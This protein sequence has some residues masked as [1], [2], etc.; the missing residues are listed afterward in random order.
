MNRSV[1]WLM[2]I[3]VTLMLFCAPAA[4]A[5]Y[6]A[7]RT[8]WEVGRYA[9]AMKEWRRAVRGDAKAAAERNALRRR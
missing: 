1:M 9:E 2:L 3:G 6:G 8:A 5:D 7:G 4:W